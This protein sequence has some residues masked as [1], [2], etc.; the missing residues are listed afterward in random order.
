[1]LYTTEGKC[2]DGCRMPE[3]PRVRLDP[4]FLPEGFTKTVGSVADTKTEQPCGARW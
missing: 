2:E 4:V 1:M 3:E